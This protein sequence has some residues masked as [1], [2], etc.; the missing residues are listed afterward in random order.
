MLNSDSS[1]EGK[2]LENPRPIWEKKKIIFTIQFPKLGVCFELQLFVCLRTDSEIDA[3]SLD[4]KTRL[5]CL[6]LH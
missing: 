2:A 4:T 6:S 5:I 3:N 1:Q